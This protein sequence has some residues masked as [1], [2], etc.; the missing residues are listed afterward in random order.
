M[1]GKPLAL[2]IVISNGSISS[3]NMF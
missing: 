2:F 3:Y 1:F